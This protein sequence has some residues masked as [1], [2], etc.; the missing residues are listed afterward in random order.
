LPPLVLVGNKGDLDFIRQVSKNEGLEL[1][2]KLKCDFYESSAREGWSKLI[3]RSENL[4]VACSPTGE[5][6]TISLFAGAAASFGFVGLS[7]EE[8]SRKV[9]RCLTPTLGRKLSSAAQ[10]S[11]GEDRSEKT[12]V[13]RWGSFHGSTRRTVGN[14]LTAHGTFPVHGSGSNSWNNS[15]GCSEDDLD[16]TKTSRLARSPVRGRKSSPSTLIGK[17][18]PRLGR[19][20]SK[21][22][23]PSEHKG[24]I[25]FS[26]DD[27]NNNNNK[28]KPLP[29]SIAMGLSSTLMASAKLSETLLCSNTAKLIS[30][31]TNSPSTSSANS[32]STSTS[33][34]L[35]NL[36]VCDQEMGSSRSVTHTP[37]RSNCSVQSPIVNEPP[38]EVKLYE[39]DFSSSEPFLHLCRNQLNRNRIRSR[40]PTHK[41]INGIKK[42]RSLAGEHGSN[43]QGLHKQHG[44]PTTGQNLL[45]VPIIKF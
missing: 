38:K 26:R 34:S 18:S 5:V 28:I 6:D 45:S 17:L 20:F 3:T 41:I 22:T 24:N 12:I 15:P 37:V 1:A 4:S 8:I 43:G 19:K 27:N 10:F 25:K 42:I 13:R 44:I 11:D 2:E 21:T 9:T 29:N 30:E 16:D 7:H 33:G 23:A 36:L 32:A 40:S 14:Q 39:Q 35:E 31:S